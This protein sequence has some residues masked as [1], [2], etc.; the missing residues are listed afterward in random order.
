MTPWLWR[1]NTGVHV[2]HVKTTVNCA[3]SSSWLPAMIRVWINLSALQQ[4]PKMFFLNLNKWKV[5]FSPPCDRCCSLRPPS[6][7]RWPPPP[8][9]WWSASSWSPAWSAA[10]WAGPGCPPPCIP[11]PGPGSPAWTR[12]WW[13]SARGTWRRS[14]RPWPGP[15]SAARRTSA[16]AASSS[17]APAPAFVTRSQ[18]S[19]QNFQSP[20]RISFRD[21]LTKPGIRHLFQLGDWLKYE[22]ETDRNNNQLWI[23]KH[24]LTINKTFQKCAALYKCSC[25]P[26]D[27]AWC[28]SS[29]RSTD[30]RMASQCRTCG[31]RTGCGSWDSPWSRRCGCTGGS[32]SPCLT[33]PPWHEPSGHCPSWSPGGAARTR[34]PGGAASWSRWPRRSLRCSGRGT[35][36]GLRSRGQSRGHGTREMSDEMMR[37]ET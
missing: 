18:N 32:A 8:G 28:R 3:S 33:S 30:T 26:A 7:L 22:P 21:F 11:G 27:S 31:A 37:G 17:W 35:A 29:G 5:P 6:P 36:S 13:C 19:G 4:K 14:W 2:T 23:I 9:C 24:N 25:L 15:R 1:G 34:C 10:C 12:A 16:A 20:G